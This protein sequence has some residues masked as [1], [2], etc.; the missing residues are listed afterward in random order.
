MGAVQDRLATFTVAPAAEDTTWRDSLADFWDHELTTWD[1][2]HEVGAVQDLT[3]VFGVDRSEIFPI[4]VE[5]HSTT[6][7]GIAITRARAAVAVIDGFAVHV[8]T[9]LTGQV[10][11]AQLTESGEVIALHPKS[12]SGF[13]EF[14]ALVAD[15]DTQALFRAPD[16]VLKALP[17]FPADI[18]DVEVVTT[19]SDNTTQQWAEEHVA[20]ALKA[21]GV[22]RGY[23]YRAPLPRTRVELSERSGVAAVAFDDSAFVMF[24][25][26]LRADLA[27]HACRGEGCTDGVILELTDH[28]RGDAREQVTSRQQLASLIAQIGVT[29]DRNVTILRQA[30]WSEGLNAEVQAA[31]LALQPQKKGWWR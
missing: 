16:T 25:G 14:A 18:H 8:T 3:R 26:R 20:G 1:R 23:N 19:G 9:G 27:W 28:T 31:Y 11:L 22:A 29:T 30:E 4:L 24:G 2:E 17:D 13:A 12:L 6:Y 5:Q 10:R 15:E 7:S 21:V